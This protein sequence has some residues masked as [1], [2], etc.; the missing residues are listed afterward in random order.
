M[1]SLS[2]MGKNNKDDKK[3]NLATNFS[4]MNVPL[5]HLKF[6]RKGAAPISGISSQ[7][8]HSLQC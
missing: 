4:H 7:M 1:C 8:T 3:A 6:M 5:K 2:N